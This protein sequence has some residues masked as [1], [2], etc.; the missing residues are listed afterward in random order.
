[1]LQSVKTRNNNIIISEKERIAFK[2]QNNIFE[3]CLTLGRNKFMY[4]G[5]IMPSI[6]GY[7]IFDTTG[8]YQYTI[9]L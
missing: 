1:M 5:N 4:N 7:S 2:V 6:F 8:R 3:T 9:C